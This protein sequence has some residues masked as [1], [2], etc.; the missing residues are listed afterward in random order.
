MIER[1]VESLFASSYPR[2][3]VIVVD[4]GSTD[5]TPLLLGLSPSRASITMWSMLRRLAQLGGVSASLALVLAAC[6]GGHASHAVRSS[7]PLRVTL[8][9]LS[10]DTG[11]TLGQARPSS[12]PLVTLRGGAR[13][14]RI[15]RLVPLPPPP[16]LL[17][18]NAGETICL[19]VIMTIGLSDDRRLVYRGCQRPRALRPVLAR[20][21]QL[22]DR[23]GFCARYR[24]ELRP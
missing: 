2:C 3:E 24:N 19:P 10:P 22:L 8:L 23:P 20:L 9:S 1:C 16:P 5:A 15:A 14:A 18:P 6:G 4:D 21:C 17:G 7:G 11:Y 13:F 12:E